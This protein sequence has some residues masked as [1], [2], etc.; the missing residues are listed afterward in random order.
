MVQLLE[1]DGY[2]MPRTQFLC[3]EAALEDLETIFADLVDKT[4]P[5]WQEAI[6]EFYREA[7]QV[8]GSNVELF[9]AYPDA[10]ELLY[11]LRF[12]A[13]C[14]HLMEGMRLVRGRDAGRL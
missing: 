12:E 10:A 4:T 8:Y 2:L 9:Q 13:G 5:A 3:K 6:G 14:Q 1:S 7:F 11:W